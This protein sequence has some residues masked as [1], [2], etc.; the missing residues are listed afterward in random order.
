MNDMNWAMYPSAAPCLIMGD[1]YHI[2]KLRKE[3]KPF[4]L[5]FGNNPSHSSFAD[6]RLPEN[7]LAAK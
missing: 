4:C 2:L 1:F 5:T 7:N 6:E 3:A